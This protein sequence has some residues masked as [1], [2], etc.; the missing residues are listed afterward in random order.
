VDGVTVLHHAHDRSWRLRWIVHFHHC[1]M[2]ARVETLA[3][4]LDLADTEVAE[5]LFEKTF[6]RAHAFDQCVVLDRLGTLGGGSNRPL[7]IVGDHQ[8]LA[9]KI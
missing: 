5:R 3:E 2:Q 7:E 9:R 8:Q 4:C 6:G 1:F